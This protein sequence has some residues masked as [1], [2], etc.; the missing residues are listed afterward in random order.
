MM[1]LERFVPLKGFHPYFQRTMSE[2]RG[3]EEAQFIDDDVSSPWRNFL[4]STLNELSRTQSLRDFMLPLRD[5]VQNVTE[6]LSFMLTCLVG[7]QV[8]LVL[9]I[10]GDFLLNLRSVFVVT[11]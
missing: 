3:D 8:L 11:S 2:S 6:S 9:I 4:E 1:L 5:Y 7:L 10:L